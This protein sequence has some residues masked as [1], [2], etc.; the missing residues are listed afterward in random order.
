MAPTCTERRVSLRRC[1]PGQACTSAHCFCSSAGMKPLICF[2]GYSFGTHI[3]PYAVCIHRYPAERK[4]ASTLPFVT[5]ASVVCMAC[6]RSSY[7]SARSI[8]ISASCDCVRP[9]ARAAA[10]MCRLMT[11]VTLNPSD[12]RSLLPGALIGRPIRF[13]GFVTGTSHLIHACPSF[14]L[15]TRK[16]CKTLTSR[17]SHERCPQLLK[18]LRAPDHR[19]HG[20]GA[21]NRH[22]SVGAPARPRGRFLARM[23]ES[24]RR[25]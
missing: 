14:L 19:E 8:K 22:A 10:S 20:A 1:P 5:F 23:D 2:S 16:G 13:A 6:S 3:L 9:D 12:T 15:I 25:V 18:A 24:S 17:A 7:V 21:D 11:A 4:A